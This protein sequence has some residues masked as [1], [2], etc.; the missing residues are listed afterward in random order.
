MAQ[1]GSTK[2]AWAVGGTIFAATALLLIGIWQILMGIAAIAQDSFFVVGEDYAYE[3]DTTT[4]GWI[5]LGIGVL[6]AVT[7]FFLFTG[8]TWA[9]VVGIAIAVIS[10][11]ANFFFIPYYPVWSL[12]I[13]ALDVFA[14]WAIAN[15]RRET[16]RGDGMGAEAMAGSYGAGQTQV[17]ERWPADQPATAGRHYASEREG[18]GTRAEQEAAQQRQAAESIARGGGTRPSTGSSGM[19]G[20]MPPTGPQ[21]PPM[22]PR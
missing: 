10:A 4:W 3:I 16:M 11:T 6:A 21:E 7:G 2:A 8:A 18:T 22:P 5:H 1:T 15:V 20:G 12:L 14:I 17:G 9:R 13:I 19:T